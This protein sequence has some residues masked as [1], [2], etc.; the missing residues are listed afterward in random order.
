MARFGVGFGG[1]GD[2]VKMLGRAV[3]GVELERC[4]AGVADIVPRSGR[5]DHR[6][7]VDD[8][9][10]IVVDVDLAAAFLEAEKL[11]AVFVHLGPDF[12][13]RLQGHQH[14]LEV[15]AG[16]EHAAKIRIVGGLMLDIVVIAVHCL[17]PGLVVEC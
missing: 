4:D 1:V 8:V 11:V 10:D 15:L 7:A 17:P 2:G 3:E 12:L 5:D 14:Q 6:A 9:I 13:A 16:V